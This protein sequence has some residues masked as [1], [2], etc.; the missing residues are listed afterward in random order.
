MISQSEPNF[1]SARN[2]INSRDLYAFAEVWFENSRIKIQPQKV[3]R[4]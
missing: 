3:S 4:V 1:I 2:F